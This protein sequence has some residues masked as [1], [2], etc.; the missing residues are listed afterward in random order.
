MRLPRLSALVCSRRIDDQVVSNPFQVKRVAVFLAIFLILELAWIAARGSWLYRL[1]IDQFT[2]TTAVF[3][4]NALDS[5]A[6]AQALNAAIHTGGMTV[7]ILN[8][9]EGIDILFLLSA[10]VLTLSDTWQGKSRRI[11]ILSIFVVILNIIRI[12][13]LVE[14]ARHHRQYFDL[15]HGFIAPIIMI[16]VSMLILLKMLP[17]PSTTFPVPI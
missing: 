4:I 12:V 8:G 11:L 6:S 7:N 10:V 1:I 2:V 13:V 3:F 14:V 17:K 5:S 9:C 15:V 16:A